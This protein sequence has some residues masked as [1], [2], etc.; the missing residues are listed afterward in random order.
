M[1]ER[2]DSRSSSEGNGRSRASRSL[3]E[4]AAAEAFV[5]VMRRCRVRQFDLAAEAWI[6]A[7][8]RPVAGGTSHEVV[9]HY[10][11]APPFWPITVNADEPI[12]SGYAI[13]AHAVPIQ[14]AQRDIPLNGASD[15]FTSVRTEFGPGC[16]DLFLRATN[17]VP[18]FVC[19]PLSAAEARQVVDEYLIDAIVSQTGGCGPLVASGTALPPPSPQWE[20]SWNADEHGDRVHQDHQRRAARPVRL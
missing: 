15:G 4:R 9:R 19:E 16:R 10:R 5:Y 6:S 7:G 1:S 20:P 3:A 13:N 14:Y 12:L 18:A 2:A 11:I 8:S 17:T